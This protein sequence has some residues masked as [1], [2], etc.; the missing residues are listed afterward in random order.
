MTQ[1]IF[2]ALLLLFTLAMTAWPQASSS[3]VRGTVHDQAGAIVPNAKVEL[4]NT[5]T[6]V[7]RITNTNDAGLYVFPGVI[8]GPYR[9]IAESSGMQRYEATLTLLVQQDAAVDITLEVA[10][11]VTQVAVQDVTPMVIVDR[12]TLGHVLERQRIEQLPINGRGYQSLLQT[13][14][15]IDST[16][17][18]QAY[19]MRTNTNTTLFDGAPVNEVWEGWDFGRPPGLDAVQEF[20]VELNNSSAK[21]TRPAT[22]LMT[23]KSGTNQFHGALFE[24]NRNSGYGV[25]RRRQDTFTK[26]PF[27]NRNEF[28]ASA[29]GPIIIPRLYNGR[30]QTFF[31]VAWEAARSMTYTTNQYRVP[32]VAMRNGDFRGLVDSQ[33]RQIQLFDPFTTDPTTWQRQPLSYR[34]VPNM[35]DPARISPIAKLLFDMTPL[36]TLPDTNPLIDV[37]WIGATAIPNKQSTTTIRIDH[38]F[39]SNDLLYGRLTYG[40]N[41]HWLG[42]SM[43]LPTNI[44]DYPKV[45]GLTNRHWPNHTGSATW[46]RTFSP[47]LTNELLL[48][49]SRDYHWR[50]SGDAHTDYAGA[51]GVPNPFDAVNWPVFSGADLP[52]GASAS[53]SNWPFSSAAPFW[54]VTNYG[55]LQDNATKIMGKHEF[56][57]GFHMRHERI[58]KSSVSLAGPFDANTLATAQYDPTSTPANPIARPLTGFGLAN[59]SLGAVNYTA[60]FRRPWFHFRRWE[61]APYFQ[62][63]WKVSQRLTLNLG[64]RY[65]LRTPMYDRDGTLLTFD[66]EKRALVVGTEVDQ[67]VKMNATLPS[68]LT[69]VRQFG[70]NII[71]YKDAGLPQK[72]VY[73]NWRQFGPRLGFAYRAFDG[74]RAFV[75]RGGYRISYYP[76]K[77]QDWVGSQSSSIPVGANFTYSVTNTALSPDGLPNYGLRSIPQ[78]IAGVSSPDSIIN[79]NDTR[80]L[81]RGFG[82]QFLDPHHTDGRVQDWNFTVEKEI[83]A[84]TVFRAAYVGNYGDRQQQWVNYNDQTPEYIW[85]VTTREPLPTGPFASVARRSYDRTTYGNINLFTASGYGRYNGAQFEIE[86]RYNNGLAFQFFWN[87]GNTMLVNRDTDDTQADDSIIGLNNFLPGAVPTDLEARN[88]FLNYKRDPN[89]PKHQ[90][91]WNFV[92]DLP[93]GRGKKF[94]GG[95]PG[96]VN[97]II[98]GWQVA[99]LGSIRTSYWT[100]PTNVYPTGNNIEVYGEKY[101]IEDCRSGT[102]YPGYLYWN[103]YIPSNRINSRDANGKPNGIMGLPDNYK[104][105][106]APLIPWGSTAVPANAPAG[107]NIQS[108]WDT[109]TV[110][111]P[112][113][114]GTV[115]RTTFNDNLHPW[116]NQYLP[117]VRQWFQ[118]ASLFKFFRVTERVTFRLNVD[119]FNVFNNPNNPTAVGGDGILSTRNSGSGARTMQ[120]GARLAW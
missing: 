103:G 97:A 18:V 6:N 113:K 98:G 74:P 83:F 72:L 20:V 8:P 50:G 94:A 48:T 110:W 43:M 95:A 106:A 61:Y 34:G 77:L 23:S 60:A 78:Y 62:D 51:L 27:L 81:A 104:P 32:T 9:L 31:F 87:I 116:R 41:D 101:P 84:N 86:R 64:L 10:Q 44:G 30:N 99:G 33:G 24:T 22:I 35:I 102:C 21:F 73:T 38:R 56:Q 1:R 67:F 91:R 89:T 71:S 54:L 79:T 69:A 57:F 92:A 63:N 40:R 29:G 93:F 109:N 47:T 66:L 53:T 120:L 82:A 39:G 5:A 4:T 37:N 68:I 14:P 59:L 45:A 119:F 15:G 2:A 28:G 42:N 85:Y 36:P 90:L 12:P 70:G 100:L 76:Q 105:A 115:Q 25:A 55:L 96:V 118:D 3:T 16:G 11:T 52:I 19:G 46:V 80:L 65:E 26:A 112:L 17:I 7:T 13:V 111:V 108:L 88:R 49:A 114:D 107:T 75:L 117:G 58:E